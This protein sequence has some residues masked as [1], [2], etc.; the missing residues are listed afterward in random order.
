MAMSSGLE[1]NEDQGLLNDT[2]RMELLVRDAAAFARDKPLAAA[3]GTKFHYGSGSS[4]LLARIWQ[5]AI[6]AAA[7]TYPNERL[8]KPLG[9]TSAWRGRVAHGSLT[10]HSDSVP[11]SRSRSVRFAGTRVRRDAA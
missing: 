6:G 3:P 5:N 2:A 1:F 8:F 9:M 11:V 4:V 7:R 10:C